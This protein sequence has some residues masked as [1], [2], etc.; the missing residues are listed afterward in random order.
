VAVLAAA[1][2]GALVVLVPELTG[3]SA[4]AGAILVAGVLF[5]FVAHQIVFRDYVS[6]VL[7]YAVLLVLQEFF[8]RLVFMFPGQSPLSQY[9]V[10]MVSYLAFAMLL[11]KAALQQRIRMD[12]QGKLF[13]LFL[14]LAFAS[15]W[16]N[17][18]VGFVPKAVGS[19]WILTPFV[20]FL[21]WRAAAESPDFLRRFAR[22]IA[23]L[24]V[25]A[26]LVGLYQ[27]IAGPTY[28]DQVW[29]E[30]T[31]QF[32]IEGR[33]VY[34]F[35]HGT[36]PSM[37]IFSICADH[38]SFAY[39]L[40]AGLVSFAVLRELRERAAV[41]AVV[42]VPLLLAALAG[43]L[44]RTAWVCAI[45]LPL[46]FIVLSYR[47]RL[48][49]RA[50]LVGLLCGYLLAGGLTTFLYERF[51]AQDR[52]PFESALAQRAFG[53]GTLGARQDMGKAFIQGAE[54]F[55]VLGRG[56]GAEPFLLAKVAPDLAMLSSDFDDAHNFL[57]SLVSLAGLPGLILFLLW[58]WKLL[59]SGM[60]HLREAS[61]RERR[62]LCW[63]LAAVATLFLAGTTGSSTF[64]AG[65]F[66]AWCGILA[67]V[68]PAPSG[69]PAGQ[70]EP[71]GEA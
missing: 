66:W 57:I 34:D 54:R 38:F 24:A 55:R 43:S 58:F 45:L 67:G 19:A 70:R 30:S 60:Q 6:G 68:A 49:G 15:T 20:S 53:P 39:L 26:A 13:I 3:R 16:L 62:A 2:C 12:R 14:L 29:A 65:F 51:H 9:A 40:T 47:P 44:C 5:L 50:V 35:L 59:D 25:I 8:K 63:V 46:V 17:T 64:F 10:L 31:H 61:G 32:S 4:Y 23:N 41:P 71:S 18:A 33:N 48:R 11:V 1:L 7:A 69:K 36:V 21:I 56:A 42:G 27:L 28:I 52:L 37:R 22:L